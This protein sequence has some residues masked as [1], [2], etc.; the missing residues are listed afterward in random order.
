MIF[1]NKN[2]SLF[3]FKKSAMEK[4]LLP[5]LTAKSSENQCHTHTCTILYKYNT[6]ICIYSHLIKAATKQAIYIQ[7]L[8]IH[9]SNDTLKMYKDTYDKDQHGEGTI[10]SKH[11][12][13]VFSL[14]LDRPRNESVHSHLA[15]SIR[16]CKDVG[17][18]V[19][20]PCTNT[21]PLSM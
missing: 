11:L 21:T 2:M 20:S 18:Q 17:T 9:S 4:T 19:F 7:K 1:F 16:L 5:L 15:I 8:F 6:Y 3:A 12:L 14:T 13:Y 10:K